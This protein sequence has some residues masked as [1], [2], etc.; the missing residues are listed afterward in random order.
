MNNQKKY[1]TYMRFGETNKKTTIKEEIKQTV[2]FMVV[3]I[4]CCIGWY[5]MQ[6]CI[7][8]QQRPTINE[9]VKEVK[10]DLKKT[11]KPMDK[12]KSEPQEKVDSDSSEEFESQKKVESDS[13]EEC[14]SQEKVDSDSS[15]ESESQ[16]EVE[17]DSSDESESQEKVDS[18]SSEECESQ[19]EVDC[20]SSEES[21]SQKKVES[22]SSEECE[23]QEKVDS[24]SSVEESLRKKL[25]SY[26]SDEMDMSNSLG[27]TKEE[28][29]YLLEKS[30]LVDNQELIDK[31]SCVM[32][33]TVSQYE[34]NELFAL[35]VMSL[36]SGY[37]SSYLAVNYHNY[38]GMLNSDGS[39]M[40]FDSMQ[41]GLKEA[42]ICQYNNLKDG[43]NIYD[44]NDTYCPPNAEGNTGDY[45]WSTLVLS[46]MQ[47]YAS[48][49]YE[50]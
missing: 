25:P 12:P 9:V 20:D 50:D 10:T 17:S 7:F 41:E 45:E 42:I 44:V 6:P 5:F 18:N 43:G 2:T 48:A 27:L 15:E 14:E 30:G 37:F 4:I 36:E 32:A 31:L 22:D 49:L 29:R 34:V 1:R 46:I 33:D 35:S 19:E 47:M 38:G 21:E 16:K 11:V 3:I 13:S 8:M 26:I 28:M 40:R 23:S 39:A 24:D